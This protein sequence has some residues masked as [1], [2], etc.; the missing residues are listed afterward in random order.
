MVFNY[1]RYVVVRSR[2]F[3]QEP[4]ATASSVNPCWTIKHSSL[5]IE[6]SVNAAMLAQGCKN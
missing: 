1:L 3:D 6:R 2:S 5:G 4:T